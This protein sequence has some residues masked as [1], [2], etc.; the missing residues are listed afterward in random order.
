MCKVKYCEDIK[1]IQRNLNNSIFLNIF[2][3]E[4]TEFIRVKLSK[5]SFQNFKKEKACPYLRTS[6][7]I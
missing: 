6:L 4:I 3:L 1:I 2:I 5:I 7:K